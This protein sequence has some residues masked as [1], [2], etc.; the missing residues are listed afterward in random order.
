MTLIIKNASDEFANAIQ[1]L[2]KIDNAIVQL[3]DEAQAQAYP[4]EQSQ[5]YKDFEKRMATNPS[6]YAK[7]LQEVRD[8]VFNS[9]YK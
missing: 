3:Q 8:E 7:L 2:A 6:E 1:S 9:H 5:I 4:L